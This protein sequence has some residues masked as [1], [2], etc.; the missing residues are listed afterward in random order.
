MIIITVVGE[1]GSG[2]SPLIHSLFDELVTKYNASVEI[3]K[4][5]EGKNKDDFKGMV[6]YNNKKIAFCSIGD[7]AD[8]NEETGYKHIPSE[9][10]LSGLVFASKNEADILINAYSNPFDEFPESTYKSLI[11]CSNFEYFPK[12][13]NKNNFDELKAEILSKL[14][15]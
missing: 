11:S 1:E 3:E 4:A 10:I 9:Y 13:L 2:K 15:V 7:P 8:I 5:V 14:G 6:K 12:N